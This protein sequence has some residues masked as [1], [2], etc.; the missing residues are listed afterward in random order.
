V[1]AG[2]SIWKFKSLRVGNILQLNFRSWKLCQF[3][4]GCKATQFGGCVP[5]SE[6]NL[7]L[8]CDSAMPKAL[9]LKYTCV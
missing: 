7:Q 6:R 5:A 2:A 1:S 3:T 4:E 9:K 8:S